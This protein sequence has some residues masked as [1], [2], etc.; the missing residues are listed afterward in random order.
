MPALNISS[1]PSRALLLG[2][3]FSVLALL[4]ATA[5]ADWSLDNGKSALHVITIKKGKVGEVQRFRQLS[6]KL[7]A[8]GKAMV[9]IDLAS[10]DTH[11]GIRD[12]RMREMLFEVARFPNATITATVDTGPIGDM[13]PGERQVVPLNFSLSLHGMSRDYSVPVAVVKLADGGLAVSSRQPVVVKAGDFGLDAGVEALRKVAKLPAIAHAVPV[14][15]D[16]VFEPAK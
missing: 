12:K 13:K 2:A 1:R 7:G 10:V 8:D 9:E 6:G 5:L 3:A 11:I 4:P 16:L 15:F 14:T